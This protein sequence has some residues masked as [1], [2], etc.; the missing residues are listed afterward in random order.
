MPWFRHGMLASV[1][2][3]NDMGP[4]MHRPTGFKHEIKKPYL[5]VTTWANI[6]RRMYDRDPT[7]S[8]ALFITIILEVQRR[9]IMRLRREIS[10]RGGRGVVGTSLT[11]WDAAYDKYRARL[12]YYVRVLKEI[13]AGESEAGDLHTRWFLPIFRGDYS[14]I[15]GMSKSEY[16][17]EPAIPFGFLPPKGWLPDAYTGAT[18]YNQ[19]SQAESLLSGFDFV[20]RV[21]GWGR[22][23]ERWFSLS[24]PGEEKTGA[25]KLQEYIDA[26][27]E[28]AAKYWPLVAGTA[29]TVALA[30]GAVVLVGGIV[31]YRQREKVF[32][33]IAKQQPALRGAA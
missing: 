33:L 14:A 24:A 3:G 17:K 2:N 12:E 9:T 8:T 23:A 25:D 16:I 28:A 18:L 22:G 5:N 15:V 27:K 10:L 6:L 19:V 11:E 21:K 31:L 26:V 30:V 1:P 20:N 29:G 4:L 32:Q 7:P 13:R